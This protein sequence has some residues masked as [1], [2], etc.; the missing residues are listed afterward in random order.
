MTPDEIYDADGRAI[1]DAV[2]HLLGPGYLVGGFSLDYGIVALYR[3]LRQEDDV[4]SDTV[5]TRTA[6]AIRAAL[7]PQH[8]DGQ[9]KT[10]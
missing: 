7:D 2:A 4:A 1:L 6:A 8:P 9:E 3:A 5:A 10:A